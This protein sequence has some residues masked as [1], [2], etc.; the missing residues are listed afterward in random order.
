MYNANGSGQMDYPEAVTA[1]K[2]RADLL[3]RQSSVSEAQQGY[4]SAQESLDIFV[5]AASEGEP[6][7]ARS[8]V[9]AKYVGKS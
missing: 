9:R 6:L 2:L 5:E 3:M 4:L 8:V 7:H 1:Q